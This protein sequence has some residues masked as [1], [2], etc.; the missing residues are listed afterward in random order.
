MDSTS[1]RPL[2]MPFTKITQY[3]GVTVYFIL[4]GKDAKK[5]SI[6]FNVFGLN[7]ELKQFRKTTP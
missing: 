1:R 2:S 6:G 3:L 4:C 5:I 7:Y